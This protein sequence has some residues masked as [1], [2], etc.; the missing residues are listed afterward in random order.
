VWSWRVSSWRVECGADSS[1]LKSD[2]GLRQPFAPESF[3]V[4]R[5]ANTLVYGVDLREQYF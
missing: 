1:S 4:R 5:G 2:P 3:A